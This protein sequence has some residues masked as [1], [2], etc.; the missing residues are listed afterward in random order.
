MEETAAEVGFDELA[1]RL[2]H[3]RRSAQRCSVNGVHLLSLGDAASSRHVFLAA[4][5]EEHRAGEYSIDVSE[6]FSIYLS[7]A[8]LLLLA[9]EWLEAERF[10]AIQLLE[11]VEDEEAKDSF[12]HVLRLA[13]RWRELSAAEDFR[14][15]ERLRNVLVS[16]VRGMQNLRGH[17]ERSK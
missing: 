7:R 11:D 5:A 10:A 13:W 8:V 3:H 17:R 4:A 9:G 14:A 1:W 16:V 12:R 2:R 15:L 6:R